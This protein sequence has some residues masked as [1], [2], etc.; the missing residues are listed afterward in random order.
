[1]PGGESAK[2]LFAK[3]QALET[4][5]WKEHSDAPLALNPLA[6]QQCSQRHA[7]ASEREGILTSSRG[8]DDVVDNDLE[9]S[10]GF[11]VKQEVMKTRRSSR[12]I[13]TEAVPNGSLNDLNFMKVVKGSDPLEGSISC[14]ECSH[15][16]FETEYSDFK[17]SENLRCSGE[18]MEGYSRI[19]S[20]SNSVQSLTGH[21]NSL[22]TTLATSLKLIAANSATSPLAHSSVNSD[23]ESFQAETVSCTSNSNASD[24]VTP[25]V[26]L[27]PAEPSG[28]SDNATVRKY[29]T[30]ASLK[31]AEK[32]SK[33]KSSDS[34]MMKPILSKDGSV[35]LYQCEKCSKVFNK[36]QTL[37]QHFITHTDRFACSYCDT[38]CKSKGDLHRHI[39][40]HTK[41][42][43]YHCDVC[44]TDY[45]R[46]TILRKHMKTQLHLRACYERENIAR[47]HKMID[48]EKNVDKFVTNQ[49][50]VK[51]GG[52]SCSQCCTVSF[53]KAKHKKHMKSHAFKYVCGTCQKGCRSALLLKIHSRSHNRSS[54]LFCKVCSR[55]FISFYCLKEHRKTHR[56]E[57]C[58]KVDDENLIKAAI[59]KHNK[60]IAKMTKKCQV[61]DLK[62]EA[63]SLNALPKLKKLECEEC[64]K[65]FTSEKRLANHSRVHNGTYICGICSKAFSTLSKLKIHLKFH[66]KLLKCEICDAS[67]YDDKEL[68]CHVQEQ[69]GGSDFTCKLCYEQFPSGA[70]L[71]NH[72]KDHAPTMLFSGKSL[73]ETALPVGNKGKKKPPRAGIDI[74]YSDSEDSSD[75][76]DLQLQTRPRKVELPKLCSSAEN[77][78]FDSQEFLE[79]M[80]SIV[81]I[82]DDNGNDSEGSDSDDELYSDIVATL[83]DEDFSSGESDNDGSRKSFFQKSLLLETEDIIKKYYAEFERQSEKDEKKQLFKCRL[84]SMAFDEDKYL[85]NHL[86]CHFC[87]YCNKFFVGRDKLSAHKSRHVRYLLKQI[88]TEVNNL[89]SPKQKWKVS[90]MSSDSEFELEDQFLNE[91]EDILEGEPP[92]EARSVNFLHSLS[93]DEIVRANKHI[94][95]QYS[96]LDLTSNIFACTICKRKYA[97]PTT[98]TRHFKTHVCQFCNKFFEDKSDLLEHKYKHRKKAA[99]MKAEITGE[100]SKM[101]PSP[102]VSKPNRDMFK[103]YSFIDSDRNINRCTLCC[104][105]F[106]RRTVLTRHMKT[107]IC[108]HCDKFFEDKYDL[109]KHVSF[110]QVEKQY[111]DDDE[112]T[113][114]DEDD[115]Q[116]PTNSSVVG[117][118]EVHEDK[119]IAMA[120]SFT[121]SLRHLNPSFHAQPACASRNGTITF[122]QIPNT[123]SETAGSQVF[124]A[125]GSGASSFQ[126]ISQPVDVY[127]DAG[128]ESFL[129][130]STSC[131]G[132]E[133]EK[134]ITISQPQIVSGGSD[135]RE[136]LFECGECGKR[137]FK[138]GHL[139]SHMTIHTGDR[140]YVC[141]LCGKAFGRG[142]TLRKHEK[143][144]MKRCKICDTSFSHKYELDLHMEIHRTYAFYK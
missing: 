24:A 4:F 107:H 76:E 134:I 39:Q 97:R 85:K 51:L 46:E 82:S 69:H 41:E 84:C 95:E 120:S 128:Q 3:N 132:G 22:G 100:G 58:S 133:P 111:M 43:P 26:V 94:F 136:R 80:K 61:D 115:K 72:M 35:T 42:K 93:H 56:F 12:N 18:Q 96:C 66:G 131:Q 121:S 73:D 123:Q 38:R 86:R 102:V 20:K 98:L 99:L 83:K 52:F 87:E 103:R 124:T 71:Q 126:I 109:A 81:D 34:E 32:L 114:Y 137:F 60:V 78:V 54:S 44:N 50:K 14:S 30:R 40:T 15:R 90:S 116:Y 105:D 21:E 48:K 9:N 19:P 31:K 1:M 2:K 25:V 110:H 49:T 139:R 130:A 65:T 142:T 113:E 11:S 57:N 144:H 67:F 10:C 37:R 63:N 89:H 28:Q 55:S 47:L 135:E 104:K 143:T 117:N 59:S 119:N 29:P 7:L 64:H 74:E 27:S 138:N 79:I 17:K 77:C 108:S 91:L 88:K 101:P 53:S 141:R 23:G 36:K 68:E 6:L 62:E 5:K 129:V 33:R 70:D 13:K 118:L 92:K 75:N 106:V 112:F 45:T 8:C 125:P 122:I 16:P 140:P 127:K